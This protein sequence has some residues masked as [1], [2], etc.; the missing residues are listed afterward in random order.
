[1]KETLPD[2]LHCRGD[3]TNL[4]HNMYIFFDSVY[5]FLNNMMASLALE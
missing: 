4:H 3:P 1:M 2:V 5:T